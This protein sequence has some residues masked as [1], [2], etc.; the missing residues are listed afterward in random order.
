[1]YL[2]RNMLYLRHWYLFYREIKQIRSNIL[3]QIYQAIHEY[4]YIEYCRYF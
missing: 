1:M 4:M 3:L 2:R